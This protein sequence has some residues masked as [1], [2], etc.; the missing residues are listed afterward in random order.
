MKITALLLSL[1]LMFVPLGTMAG[2]HSDDADEQAGPERCIS[3]TRLEST[4]V[5]DDENILF[6]MRDGTIYRNE[7]LHKCPGLRFEETFLY[8]TYVGQLCNLDL[9]TVLNDAGFGFTHGPSCGLGQ[10][11]P[12]SEDEAKMLKKENKPS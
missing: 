9:I 5:I 6:R 3:L 11:Y 8:R 2:E 12:I 1:G 4:S 10:F 7:L